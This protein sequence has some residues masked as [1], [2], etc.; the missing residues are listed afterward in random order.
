MANVGKVKALNS[1]LVEVRGKSI[2]DDIQSH[3]D[4]F[5]RP[6]L[7]DEIIMD[8]T[9]IEDCSERTNRLC[10]L[11]GIESDSD[12]ASEIVSGGYVV[13]YA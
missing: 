4:V 9:G 7:S 8:M 6:D 1:V 13:F 10:D 5:S 12:Q 11:L 2:L 3:F